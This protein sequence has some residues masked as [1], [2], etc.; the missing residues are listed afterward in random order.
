[1]RANGA[2][3]DPVELPLSERR[4]SAVDV[5][6][7]G[8]GGG[9]GEAELLDSVQNAAH[10]GRAETDLTGKLADG[11]VGRLGLTPHRRDSPKQQYRGRTEDRGPALL[12]V[13]VIEVESESVNGSVGV[14]G[15][16]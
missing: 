13:W 7:A 14:D 15:G 4:C 9:G 11:C 3:R 12:D 10:R 6:D 16:A 5:D 8:V 2:R 1:M